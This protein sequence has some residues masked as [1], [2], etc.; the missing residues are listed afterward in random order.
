MKRDKLNKVTNINVTKVILKS[1][2][3]PVKMWRKICYVKEMP[4][5]SDEQKGITL[6]VAA[7]VLVMNS[8]GIFRN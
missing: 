1:Q 5:N 3:M 2:A 8:S 6:D 4:N 7:R